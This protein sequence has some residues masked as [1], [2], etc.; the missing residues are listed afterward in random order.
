MKVLGLEHVAIAVRDARAVARVISSALGLSTG[1]MEDV[2]K[3]GVRVIKVSLGDTD[4]ELVEPS[5]DTSSIS[6]FLEKRGE[7]LHHI[8]LRVDDVEASLRSLKEKGVPLIDE[9]PRRGATGRRIAFV[10][11]RGVGG[12]LIELSERAE[13]RTRGE[14]SR[15]S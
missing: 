5:T 3:D 10:H 13:D 11:P 12:V 8:C 6:R 2:D 1:E 14:E 7:G 4:L 9:V 15:R